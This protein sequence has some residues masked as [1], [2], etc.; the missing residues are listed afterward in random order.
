MSQHKAARTLESR[1][2]K[3]GYLFIAPFMLGSLFFILYPIVLSVIFSFGKIIPNATGYRVE[4][5]GLTNY[6]FLFF[7]D[8]TFNRTLVDTVKDMLLNVPVVVIF[9]FFIASML[10]QRFRGR[11]FVRAI[12]FLPIIVSS[13]IVVK[14]MNA[15]VVGSAM[16]GKSAT[17][18]VSGVDLSAAFTT[19]LNE[20]KLSPQ[21]VTLLTS[22][23]NN[24]ANLLAMSAIPIII[25][26]AGLQ[27]I[28]PSLYE[29]SYVE[30]ATRWEIF[31]KISLPMISPLVLVA[32]VYSVVDSFT[33]VTNQVILRIRDLCFSQFDFGVGSAMAWTYLLIVLVILAIVYAL[34]NRFVFYYD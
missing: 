14:L 21:I 30:G 23:V 9:S 1:Q 20:M 2:R 27:S 32:V 12:L 6:Q 29:A 15:D 25:F 19:Y 3:F 8:P 31:W 5:V 4:L 10:N 28:A 13:G 11:T 18:A 24:I 7:K 26:L 17:E 33:S 34:V 22:T 16:A